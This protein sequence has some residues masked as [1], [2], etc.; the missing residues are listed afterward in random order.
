MT[1]PRPTAAQRREATHTVCRTFGHAWDYITT[2]SSDVEQLYLVEL[3]CERCT[4]GRHDLVEK[5]T[6]VLVRR[7]YIAPEGYASTERMTR[8]EWRNR[9]LK[10]ILKG[11]M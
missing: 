7:K 9:F 4:M 5:G 1:K 3:R 11:K 10:S 2:Y 8:T 6:G